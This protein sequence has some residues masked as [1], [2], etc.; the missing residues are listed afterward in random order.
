MSSDMECDTGVGTGGRRLGDDCGAIVQRE[1][2]NFNNPERVTVTGH[3]VE[4]P[5]ADHYSVAKSGS[6]GKVPRC[7][8]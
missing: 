4:L 2:G 6:R 5:V 7:N 1:R 8:E 3:S